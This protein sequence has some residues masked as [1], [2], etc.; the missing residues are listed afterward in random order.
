LKK[1]EVFIPR[2]SEAPE[3]GN[4]EIEAFVLRLNECCIDLGLYFTPVYCGESGGV[5]SRAPGFADPGAEAAKLGILMQI[6]H[7]GLPGVDIRLEDGKVWQSRTELLSLDNI[8]MVKGHEELQRLKAELIDADARFSEVKAR[9]LR[10]P[11]DTDVHEAFYEASR[12]RNEVSGRIQKIEDKLYPLIEDV[13]TRRERGKLS[14]RQAE[15]RWLMERGLLDKADAVLNIEEIISDGCGDDAILDQAA[16]RAQVRIS[17]LLQSALVK[18]ALTDWQGVDA[19]LREAVRLEERYNRP[20]E[21]MLEYAM[22]LRGQNRQPEGIK[23]AEKMLYYNN[24]PDNAAPDDAM[25]RLYC[26]LGSLYDDSGRTA[27]SEA[28][29]RSSLEIWEKPGSARE[30]EAAEAH[31][32][33]GNLY[34][35]HTRMTEADESYRKA[36]EIRR[37]L[38]TR[39]PDRYEPLVAETYMEIA[40]ESRDAHRYTES[41]EMFTKAI[42]IQKRLAARDPE[43]YEHALSL[44]LYN[45]GSMCSL[46]QQWSKAER[47][48][49]EALEIRQRQYDRN[50]SANEHSLAAANNLLGFLYME[51]ESFEDSE[52]YFVAALKLRKQSAARNP[53]TFEV[54]LADV[55]KN[56][57]SLYYEG[58]RF[59]EAESVLLEGLEVVKRLM[60]RDPDEFIWDMGECHHALGKLYSATGRMDEAEKNLKSAID[61]RKKLASGSDSP[62]YDPFLA[63][64]YRSLAELYREMKKSN[65]AENACRSALRLL[66]KC[67]GANSR[68]GAMA[69]EIRELLE[70]L[71]DIPDADSTGLMS[72]SGKEILFTS[73][74][75]SAAL[76]LIEGET[77][78]DISR[79][80]HLSAAEVGKLIENIRDKV[81]RQSDGDAVVAAA[82]AAFGLTRRETEMLRFLRSGLSNEAIAEELFLSEET[83]R[84]HVRNLMK[85]LRV[86]NRTEVAE[87]TVDMLERK[88]QP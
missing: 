64:S 21:A 24:D 65:E 73:V 10:D 57:G 59:D 85:K 37:R 9:V 86:E 52:K 33:L 68:Y 15:C 18:E 60:L 2:A 83:V 81:S 56:L 32:R 51:T 3:A 61:I 71:Y 6:K 7:I 4:A 76:M 35:R 74:E 87:W 54:Y 30:P 77:P 23:T 72:A 26:L 13:Y 58:K 29:Y 88:K 75:R 70:S 12:K 27:E 17:E 48:Y 79:R 47:M 42:D 22:F 82:T 50:P 43:K 62:I 49:K 80:L 20:K 36:L 78:R 46:L 67:K 16:E 41:E 44:T 31:H 8:G 19:C 39:D 38:A 40:V 28:M 14:A 66:E 25:G 63:D 69:A 84:I 11:D 1:I 5:E 45:F 34:W 55:T 53:E